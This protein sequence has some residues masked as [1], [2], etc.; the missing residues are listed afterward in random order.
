MK[1]P[2]GSVADDVTASGED[3]GSDETSGLEFDQELGAAKETA[4]M[5]R[6][7]VVKRLKEVVGQELFRRLD[8]SK[9]GYPGVKNWHILGSHAVFSGM[10][11]KQRRLFLEDRS[12]Q[13]AVEKAG[14]HLVGIRSTKGAADFSMRELSAVYRNVLERGR[15]KA[16]TQAG[17]QRSLNKVRVFFVSRNIASR[18]LPMS[19]ADVKAMVAEMIMCGETANTVKNIASAVQEWH[20]GAGFKSPVFAEGGFSRI[21]DTVAVAVGKQ[22]RPLTPITKYHVERLLRLIGLSPAQERSV[23]MVLTGVV[24]AGRCEHVAQRRICD[25]LPGF[26][27][28]KGPDYAGGGAIFIKRQKQDRYGN[29]MYPRYSDGAFARRLERWIKKNRLTRQAGCEKKDGGNGVCRVCPPLFPKY[30]HQGIA[31]SSSSPTESVTSQMVSDGVK[32]A[33]RLIG[34]DPERITGRSMRRGA[35]TA[36]VKAKVPEEVLYLQ[37]GHGRQKAGRLYMH[38]FSPETLYAT[39]RAMG[40]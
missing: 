38:D 35:L 24:L 26:D 21:M 32:E 16:G 2:A 12:E 3:S 34:I 31:S 1:S 23:M 17:Y 11:S 13:T 40:L 19:E 33:M 22:R 29:G 36:G 30:L 7:G 25:V 14:G 10:N 28:D 9:K 4:E 15:L 39:S 6:N 20:R 37:S 27:V 18:A 5:V 8:I